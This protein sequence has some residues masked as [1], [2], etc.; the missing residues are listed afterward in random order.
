MIKVIEELSMVLKR[1]IFG[2]VLGA[3]A[4]VGSAQASTITE[5]YSFSLTGFT[6]VNGSPPLASPVSQISGSFTVTFDPTLNYSNDTTDLVVNSFTGLTID[7]ALGFSYGTSRGYFFF[8]GIQN[9]ADS[10]LAG[11]NDFALALNL[12]NPSDPQFILCNA[13]N[14][15]CGAAT[16]DANY[17]ASGFATTGNNSLWFASAADSSISNTP[18]PAALPLFA[19]GLG[20]LGLLDWRRKRK[21]RVSLLGA[22]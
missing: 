7:S 8:G 15:K 1:A 3:V 5:T 17:A 2:A 21:S 12:S 19:T 20:G 10:V 16:G 22:A 14:I 4:L 9:N 11:T 13:P 6:D 18:L